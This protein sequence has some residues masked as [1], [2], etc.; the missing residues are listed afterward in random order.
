MRAPAPGGRDSSGRTPTIEI[1]ALITLIQDTIDSSSWE[2]KGGSIG[3][4]SSIGTMLVVTQKELN[5]A[6]IQKL[7]EDIRRNTSPAQVLAIRATWVQT[8]AK[9]LLTPTTEVS[10]DWIAKQKIYCESQITCFSGQTVHISSGITRNFVSDLTPIVGTNAVAF[11]PTMQSL[12]SGVS[13]QV[14]PQLTLGNS[15]VILDVQSSASEA[16][17]QD[18]PIQVSATAMQGG[19]QEARTIAN[20]DRKSVTSQEFQTTVRVPLNRKVIVG[21]MSIAPSAPTESQRQLY[22]V[23]EIDFVK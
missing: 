17:V 11:D 15:T 14:S 12:L 1:D 22:L 9:E 19:S 2:N 8:A 5:H 10:A 16:P 18:A 6:A 3:R 4:V 13:L 7:L 23:V 21:G 20:I